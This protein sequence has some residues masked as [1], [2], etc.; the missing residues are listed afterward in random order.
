MSDSQ[1]NSNSD[2][3]PTPDVRIVATCD[4]CGMPAAPMSREKTEDDSETNE[5]RCPEC[6]QSKNRRSNSSGSSRGSDSSDNRASRDNSGSQGTP[7]LIDPSV[8]ST[9]AGREESVQEWL[10]RELPQHYEVED[11]LFHCNDYIAVYVKDAELE[12]RFLLKVEK[13][14]T[15][16]EP[17]GSTKIA[18]AELVAS[19][20]H[21]HLL[22]VYDTGFTKEG[23]L[24]L[25]ME[26]PG[27]RHLEHVIQE[28]GF[29][30]LPVAL[31][32]FEQY[33]EAAQALHELSLTHGAIRPRSFMIMESDQTAD[34]I[35]IGK[36]T[37]Y[38]IT[39]YCE[40]NIKQP[41]KVGRNYTCIDAFYWSPEECNQLPPDQKAEIYS[42][43]CVLFHSITG[44][45][46][47]RAR[48][49]K[50]AVKQH[51]DDTRARF[52]RQYEIPDD[53]QKVV[54]RL[55][56]KEPSKR[57]SDL[58]EVS[59]ALSELATG[60]KIERINIWQKILKRVKEEN[61]KRF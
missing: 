59:L 26:P 19:L 53:V 38:G 23:R 58:K 44:K 13:R 7:E 1:D 10:D 14:P 43:G 37:N 42:F 52:R 35:P 6:G 11:I 50:E 24:Y 48:D 40:D 36:L 4:L 30:D 55:L 29:L 61:R 47:F 34:G 5:D 2:S 33:C 39:R 9:E 60:K 41:T 46:V 12:K 18:E 31:A 27:R 21:P 54:L 51:T 57:Y 3:D 17:V 49:L 25:L 16:G 28:E 22:T 15:A 45:P 20:N 32:L 8:I 56:E